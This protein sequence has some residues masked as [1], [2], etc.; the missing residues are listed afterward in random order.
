LET[1]IDKLS[2]SS[3]E[4]KATLKISIDYGIDNGVIVCAGPSEAFGRNDVHRAPKMENKGGTKWELNLEVPLQKDVYEYYYVVQSGSWRHESRICHRAVSVKGLKDGD[5]VDV[6]D[7]FRSTKP[8]ILAT[9][10]FDR[11]IFGKGSDEKFRESSNK[12]VKQDDL[13]WDIEE[14]GDVTVRFSVYAP[15]V[16]AGH[17]VWVTGKPESMGA[18]SSSKAVP[19]VHVGHRIY[20]GQV[21]VKKSDIPLQYKYQI[22]DESG[23]IACSEEGDNH[24]RS[25]NDGCTYMMTDDA[26]SYPTKNYRS[27]GVALPV[28]GIKTRDSTGIGEFL[29][30]KKVVDWCA[31][32]G[33]QLIQ[34]LPI[35]DS[36]ED[37]SPYSASSS[38]ALHPSY[39]RPSS[40]C[41]YYEKKYGTDMSGLK[42]WSRALVEKLNSNWQIDHPRVM[43]EKKKLTDAIFDKVTQEKVLEDEDFQ[44]WLKKQ[45]HWVKT[46]AAFKVQLNKERQ[47]NNKWWDS[48]TW[49]T[50]ASQAEAIVHPHGQDYNQVARVYFT[51]YH[52]H[53]QLLEA[54]AY[55]EKKGVALKGDIPIGVTRCSADVW[56]EP[57]LF[58][59]DRNAGAPG[60]PEQN[61]GF[62]P[63]NW[64]AMHKDGCHWWRRRLVKPKTLN[65][66]PE[67]LNPERLRRGHE[68]E[69]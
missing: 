11:A 60:D 8:A 6:Q 58:K 33:L 15:R 5:V 62:P 34:V 48:S 66:K 69:P 9:A 20:I 61:W 35:N 22:A 65:P 12:E 57:H 37:P 27:A 4:G 53:V 56:A 1:T 49:T 64:E 21:K 54:T 36:G 17:S 7:R 26:F 63:Y 13:R 40:M 23:N 3:A 44:K 31:E 29:D 45:D 47:F 30:L 42:G 46:Y 50:R 41:E 25:I 28:S 19:M 52:L 14:S 38:F 51:Q 10:A 67:S 24:Q 68:P 16:E 55:A 32:T 2:L 39:I 43:E 59:L 18:W